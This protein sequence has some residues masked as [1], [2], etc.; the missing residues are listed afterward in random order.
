MKDKSKDIEE[1]FYDKAIKWLKN[2]AVITILLIFIILYSGLTG[3][4]KNTK[5]NHDN[6]FGA[7]GLLTWNDTVQTKPNLDTTVK[8]SM[9]ND[10]SKIHTKPPEI[11]RRKLLTRIIRDTITILKSDTV[12]VTDTSIKTSDKYFFKLSNL[13]E[14]E[15][16]VDPLTN[17]SVS[18]FNIEE[19]FTASAILDYPNGFNTISFKE[20]PSVKVRPG[21][22]WKNIYYNQKKYKM[23]ITEIN[24]STKLFSAEIR[25]IN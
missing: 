20:P 14:G 13:K 19:D 17:S 6:L 25:Q 9:I 11:T 18:V 15:A 23:T 1:T 22:S 4:I 24:H 16:F 7:G 21:D 3:L 5:E 8:V 12:F 10:A 2:R